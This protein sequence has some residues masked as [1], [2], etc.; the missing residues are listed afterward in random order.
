ML[1][2]SGLSLKFRPTFLGDVQKGY[3]KVRLKNYAVE[4]ARARDWWSP[5]A[6]RGGGRAM[7]KSRLPC[8]YLWSLLLTVEMSVGLT[9]AKCRCRAE[10]KVGE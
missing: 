2:S 9:V 10:M 7:T 1:Y 8:P 4:L 5:W 6:C 3:R